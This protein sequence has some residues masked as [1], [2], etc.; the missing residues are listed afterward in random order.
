MPRDDQSCDVDLGV[1]EG[2][3]VAS[4]LTG[5]GVFSSSCE[6]VGSGDRAGVAVGA[7]VDGRTVGCDV[8]D[9]SGCFVAVG[10]GVLSGL[11]VLVGRSVCSG[12]GVSVVSGVCSGSCV[13][14]GCSGSA[15]SSG[16]SAVHWRQRVGSAVDSSSASGGSTSAAVCV[17]SGVRVGLAVGVGSGVCVGWGTGVPT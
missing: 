14:G 16:G 9:C 8:G 10:T 3:G 13:S 2:A 4:L 12:S 15:V 11:G 17:G 5:V 6:C 7:A 1:R